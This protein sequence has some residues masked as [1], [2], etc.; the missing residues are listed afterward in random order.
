[1]IALHYD[2]RF[3]LARGAVYVDG[4]PHLYMQGYETDSSPVL[5]GVRSVARLKS[6]AGDIAF[7]TLAGGEDAV[8][9]GAPAG[10]TQGAAV[11]IEITAEA[12]RNKLARGRF[13]TV[14]NGEARRLSPPLNLKDR[15][16]ARAGAM[17]GGEAVTFDS[18][19]E[20]LDSAANEAR[21]PSGSLANGGYLAVEPTSALIA[22]D[23]DTAG[24]GERTIAAPKAF[25][26]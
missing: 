17:L 26:K 11:E 20:A 5:L 22:C 1:M 9:E 10:L 18:D 21:D 14:G 12:R 23:I 25:A 15:L 6:R 4:R 2:S 16:L 13:L 24:G 8:L 19:A 3:G 7:L